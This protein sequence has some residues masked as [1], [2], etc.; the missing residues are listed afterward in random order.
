METLNPRSRRD[1]FG[2]RINR[3]QSPI[4]GHGLPWLTVV[5]GSL[6]PWL[7]I[8]AA[9]PVVPPMGFITL[10]AWRLLRPGL[11]PLWAGVPLGLVDDLFS[12]QPVGSGILLFSITLLA[13]EVVEFR[14]PW[15]GFLLDWALASAI[16]GVYL[17]FAA[18]FSGADITPVQLTVIVPQL[19]I[20]IVVYPLVARMIAVLDRLRLMRVRR[21]S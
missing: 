5:L 14:L 15:R 2:T 9:A 12:G 3:A 7:P 19:I 1:S 20:S 17:S 16:L 18:L 10:L 6:T 4:L 13:I 11:F 21:I 8:I